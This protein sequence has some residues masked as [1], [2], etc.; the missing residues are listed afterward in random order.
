MDPLPPIS[1]MFTLMSQE[2]NQRS[3][4]GWVADSAMFHVKHEVNKFGH[5]KSQKNKRSICTH[6][7]YHGHTIEKCYKLH[8]Y[9]PSYKMKQRNTP[10]HYN[11]NNAP[12]QVNVAVMG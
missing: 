12:N 3:V 4:I 7:G 5:N 10:N 9:P 8:G 1:K 2:E 6:C 11:N